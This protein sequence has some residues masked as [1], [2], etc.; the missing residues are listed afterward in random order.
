MSVGSGGA[1][2]AEGGRGFDVDVAIVGLG[3]VGAVLS[4][5]LGQQGVRVLAIDKATDIYPLPRAAHFDHEIMRIF[6]QAGVADA[7]LEHARP[8]GGYEFR[9]ASG[10]LLYVA[11]QGGEQAI[12]GWANSYMFN[13]PG[14]E[15]AIRARLTDLPSVAVRLAC[16]FEG[17]APIEGGV[18]VALSG[19]GAP[20]SVTAR[21]LVGCDGAWSPVREAIGAKLL[22]EQFDEPWLV[23]D[24]IPHDPAAAPTVNLQLCDPARPTTCVMMGPGRHRW[25]FMMLP[26]ETPEQVLADGFVEGLLVRWNIA[27]TIE[28]KAVYRFHGL[29]ADRWRDGRVLIA[30][31]AAHQ[32]P[33]FAGQGM[34][35]GIRDAANLAWKLPMVLA[36]EAAPALLDTYQIEREPNVRA[37]IRLAI[38][39]GKVVCTLD[40][41]VAA[42]RDAAM[43]AAL[44][45]GDEPI[46]PAAPPPLAGPAI[47]NGTA[48]AGALFPQFL[49]D[50]PEGIARMDEAFGEGAW[51]IGRLD[52]TALAAPPGVRAIDLGE[53]AAAPFAVPI[54]AWLAEQGAEA[55]LVRPDRHVF[56]TGSAERLCAAW[57][58]ALQPD[59]ATA[60]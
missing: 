30:G 5:L 28:R 56:G 24:T 34:C 38:D 8:A 23:V 31:D 35:A 58:G 17:H 14:V 37:Y 43:L 45:R 4:V 9:S 22:D 57:A 19:E 1:P 21:Y 12:S 41:E 25:E 32:T 36:G 7:V 59:F 26:G 46:A 47:L 15:R 48:G 3:P 33:P 55:V 39:M 49:A 11:R 27:L 20:A 18:R 44:A 51:L 16:A 52:G 60:A 10:E 29:V 42:R 6:Q 13:Q 2:V 50:L 53:A 40:P 54:A